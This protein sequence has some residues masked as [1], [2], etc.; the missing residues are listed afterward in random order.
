MNFKTTLILIVLL[1]AAGVYLITTRNNGEE[2][3]VVKP[4]DKTLLEL[5]S[6]DVNKLSITHADGTA[7]TFEKNGGEWKMTAPVSAPAEKSEVEG[8]IKQITDLKS[9]GSNEPSSATGLDKPAY[10]IELTTTGALPRDA[11]AC[12]GLERAPEVSGTAWTCESTAS[13]K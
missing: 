2:S 9:T 11:V 6:A 10:T 1:G 7:T 4:N 13:A 5:D 3:V 8:L 12:P